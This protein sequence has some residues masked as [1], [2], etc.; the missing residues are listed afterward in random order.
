[1][2]ISPG[3]IATLLMMLFVYGWG[4]VYIYFSDTL[5]V[6]RKELTRFYKS[7]L[8]SCLINRIDTLKYAGRGGTYQV[9]YS[10][11]S[12]AYYPIIL[13]SGNKEVFKLNSL[14]SKDSLSVDIIISDGIKFYSAKISNPDS[15]DDRGFGI[16]I[17]LGFIIVT[18]ILILLM[19]SSRFK[20]IE[21]KRAAHNNS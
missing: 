16:K 5:E 10:D 15:M 4:I 20:R 21:S 7:R 12:N 14:I 6:T 19:P 1:M 9:F 18:T 11:C 13:E 2:I 17:L 8:D 3:K